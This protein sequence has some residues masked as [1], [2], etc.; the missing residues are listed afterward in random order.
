MKFDE[1]QVFR[2][3]R[4]DVEIGKVAGS[5]AFCGTAAPTN[6]KTITEMW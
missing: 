1:G 5:S 4:P 6:K 3:A 2:L